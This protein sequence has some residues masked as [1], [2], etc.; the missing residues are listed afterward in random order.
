MFAGFEAAEDVRAEMQLSKVVVEQ[1]SFDWEVSY[2]F[3]GFWLLS[4]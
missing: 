4:V 2:V 3:V 1:Y